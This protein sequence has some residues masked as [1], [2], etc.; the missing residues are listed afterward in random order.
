MSNSKI[1]TID[2]THDSDIAETT[3]EMTAEIV[4]DKKPRDIPDDL[5]KTLKFAKHL[6]TLTQTLN[7]HL[8][9]IKDIKSELKK[10][11]TSYAQDINKVYKSKRK[12]ATDAKPI[13]F[14]VGKVLPDELAKI[15]GVPNGT[16]MSMPEYTRK[17]YKELVARKLI[18]EKDGRVFRTDNEIKK[19][20]NINDS[21]NKS[22][23]H[24]DKTG[25]NFSTL[26]GYLSKAMKKYQADISNN[27][28]VVDIE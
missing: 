2:G 7:N 4:G 11:E 13:G 16:L 26:Q 21:V 9:V 28:V 25:F 20:F 1:T 3:A 6:E 19:V 8:K 15:I 5:V 14:I 22:T 27:N 24:K 12:R 23:D 18:Y 17:F 10:L